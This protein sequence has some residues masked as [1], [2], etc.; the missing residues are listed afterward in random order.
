MKKMFLV[1][2]ASICLLLS[3]SKSMPSIDNQTFTIVELNGV[4]LSGNEMKTPAISFEGDR[5]NA[6]VGG[7]EIFAVY[8]SEADGTIVFSEGGSTKM[9]VPA[10][11]REDEFIEAFN[12]VARYTYEDGELCLYDAEGKLL[13]KG[14]N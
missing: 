4:A 13:I 5:V 7:N 3:C 6:T 12:K 11:L 8:K 14:V 10:E 1:M 2:A 9:A